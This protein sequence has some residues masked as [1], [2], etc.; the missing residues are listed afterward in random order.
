MFVMVVVFLTGAA[1]MLVFTLVFV[2]LLGGRVFL[3]M[4]V[5]ALPVFPHLL[6]NTRVFR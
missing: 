6:L 2:L 5:L 1:L 3:V 4:L